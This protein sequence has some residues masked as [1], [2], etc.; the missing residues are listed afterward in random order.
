MPSMS[1]LVME[2]NTRWGSCGN[3]SCIRSFI[4]PLLVQPMHAN[5]TE[6][7]LNLDSGLMIL[8]G[9]VERNWEKPCTDYGVT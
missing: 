5:Y 1:P 4:F 6:V 9:K 8:C 3:L 7:Y 2:E